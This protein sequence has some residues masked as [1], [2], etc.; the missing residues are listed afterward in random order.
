MAF[1]SA[2]T[3]KSDATHNRWEENGTGK[4]KYAESEG[5]NAKKVAEI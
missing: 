5:K 2:T 1:A 3:K 4:W